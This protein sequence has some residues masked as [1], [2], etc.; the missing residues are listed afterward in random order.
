MNADRIAGATALAAA[1]V[2]YWLGSTAGSPEAYLFPRLIAIGMGALA[3][4]I[5][6]SSWGPAARRR[7][8]L[9]P[10]IPWL[11]LAPA[12]AILTAYPWVLETVGFYAAGLAAFLAI[13]T[14]YAPRSTAPGE[15]V[16]RVAVSAAFIGALYA[17]FALLLNVQTPRGLLL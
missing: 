2:L 5:L 3:L 1:A 11:G 9:M 4:A 14:V 10:S 8:R 6:A 13:V 16:K 7:R 15:L 12:L 17:I